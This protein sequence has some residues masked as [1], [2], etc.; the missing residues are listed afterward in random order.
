M[1]NESNQRVNEGLC[2]FFELKDLEVIEIRCNFANRN[3]LTRGLSPCA[4]IK[5]EFFKEYKFFTMPCNSH[6]INRLQ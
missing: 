5:W 4:S 6:I 2:S 1:K 3:M